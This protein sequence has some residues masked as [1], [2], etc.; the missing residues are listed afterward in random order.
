MVPG[1]DRIS[2]DE[3][4]Q[5]ISAQLGCAPADV[6]DHDDLIQL[7][8]NSIRMMALA[9][10]WRKGGADI[11][12]AERAATPPFDSCYDWLSAEQAG[13]TPAAPPAVPADP[14]ADDEPF[15]L[16]PM[17]HAYWIG[18]SDEQ[19]LGGVA[20]H[21]Y[22]EF[23]GGAIDPRRLERAVA[24]LVAAHPMLR[25]RFLADGTQ[26]SMPRPG[27]SV[28][29]V[30][31]LR[32]EDVAA[33]ESVLAQLRDRKTHQRLSIEDGQVIDIALTLYQDRSRLHLDVDMLAGD[34]MSYRVLVSDL[35]DAYR[36]ATL[37]TPGYSYR[38]YC[39]RA[40]NNQAARERD[41]QWWQQ[42]IPEMPGAP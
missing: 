36:G 39:Q 10:G 20:A 11:T 7:G 38:E 1:A 3:I 19:E 2:R 42:R 15:P 9:G 25:T 40:Q 31:D 37:P 33:P 8:L 13:A 34:A 26:Q 5:T 27:R 14:V 4:R 23:D 16:A 18:R 28:F 17:Q 22:V 29:E 24:D 6:A 21:L 41:R 35:A 12:F 30:I 32:G